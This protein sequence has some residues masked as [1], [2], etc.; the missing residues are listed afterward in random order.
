[1]FR[2]ASAAETCLCYDHEKLTGSCTKISSSPQQRGRRSTAPNEHQNCWEHLGCWV[3]SAVPVHSGAWIFIHIYMHKLGIMYITSSWTQLVMHAN[4]DAWVLLFTHKIWS[5]CFAISWFAQYSKL[6]SSLTL[7]HILFCKYI[8]T[9]AHNSTYCMAIY[10]GHTAIYRL[11][12]GYISSFAFSGMDMQVS[13]IKHSMQSWPWK[14]T[15]YQTR[16][17]GVVWVD[18]LCWFNWHVPHIYAP[19]QK[20]LDMHCDS[21]TRTHACL[22]TCLTNQ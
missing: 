5:E 21:C 2:L 15:T 16:M 12:I 14:W 10:I 8:H 7:S 20:G 4:E 1:M 18:N 13:L 6:A 11:Y 9:N 22:Q 17:D 19:N 3:L